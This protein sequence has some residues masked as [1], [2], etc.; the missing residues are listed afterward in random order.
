MS[1]KV[2]EN[3]STHTIFQKQNNLKPLFYIKYP[4]HFIKLKRY[5]NFNLKNTTICPKKL[6]EEKNSS[7]A[8]VCK[9]L[10]NKH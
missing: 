1:L 2:W 8:T 7:V 9:K 4:F 3:A 10:M 5:I 6:K